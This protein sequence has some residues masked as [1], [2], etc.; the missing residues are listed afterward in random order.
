M[1]INTRWKLILP[2]MF[3]GNKVVSH[4]CILS[5]S[6]HLLIASLI[7]NR[8]HSNIIMSIIHIYH[9]LERGLKM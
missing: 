5:P 4:V 7:N 6:A 9:N 3:V 8:A 2:L 1:F